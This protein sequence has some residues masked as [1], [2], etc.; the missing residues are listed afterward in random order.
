MDSRTA[1][2]VIELNREGQALPL[3]PILDPAALIQALQKGK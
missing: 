2:R 1:A 3:G